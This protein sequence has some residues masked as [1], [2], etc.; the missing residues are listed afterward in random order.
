MLL[1]IREKPFLDEHG[2]CWEIAGWYYHERTTR[3][4]IRITQPPNHR[5][6][7]MLMEHQSMPLTLL[8][9]F[10]KAAMPPIGCPMLSSRIRLNSVRRVLDMAWCNKNCI[11]FCD[12]IVL[13]EWKDEDGTYRT[14]WELGTTFTELMRDQ[15]QYCL[16][17][18]GKWANE[19]EC[20]HASMCE[21]I[22]ESRDVTLTG[23]GWQY[24]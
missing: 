15:E 18:L 22:A 9:Q 6:T 11:N 23:V 8:S 3:Y 21:D 12:F 4:L 24:P 14:S 2:L 1:P 17:L 10:S 5:V 7:Y 19:V 16:Y 13:L 20:R